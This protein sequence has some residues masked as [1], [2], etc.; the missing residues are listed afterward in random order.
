MTVTYR[1]P[2]GQ[3]AA[4]LS[5]PLPINNGIKSKLLPRRENNLKKQRPKNS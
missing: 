1:A 2:G 4:L 5:S 3:S